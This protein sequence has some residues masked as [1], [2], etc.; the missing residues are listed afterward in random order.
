MIFEH[1]SVGTVAG[2]V[3]VSAIVVLCFTHAQCWCKKYVRIVGFTL[4]A[5]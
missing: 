2:G 3:K 4:V 5:V 1:P